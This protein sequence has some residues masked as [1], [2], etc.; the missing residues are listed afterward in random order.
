M[1]V[2]VKRREAITAGSLPAIDDALCVYYAFHGAGPG[3]STTH[4]WSTQM[5]LAGLALAGVGDREYGL[6]PDHVASVLVA[7]GRWKKSTPVAGNFFDVTLPTGGGTTAA[8]MSP[9]ITFSRSTS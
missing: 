2:P 4:C 7:L 5:L 6:V 9:T 8:P 1:L 3:K